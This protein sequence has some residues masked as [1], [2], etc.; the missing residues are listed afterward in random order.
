[1]DGKHRYLASWQYHFIRVH[2]KLVQCPSNNISISISSATITSYVSDSD[3]KY[4]G[5]L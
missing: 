1:M 3:S 4:I 2:E 5:L